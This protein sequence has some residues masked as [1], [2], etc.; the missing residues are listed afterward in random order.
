[1]E[2]F[3][4]Y[5]YPALALLV[6]LEGLG[7]PTPAVTA[8]VAASALAA[9]GQ[10]SLPA[11]VAVTL[12][13]AVLGDN[14]GYLLGRRAGRPAVLRFGRRIG[15]TEARLERAERFMATRGRNI[16]VA[17]RFVDGLRQ[18]NG[19]IAG[20]TA[21]PWRQYAPRD[22]AGGVLW[23]ALWVTIG[24]VAGNNID[25]LRRYQLWVLG[26]AAVLGLGLLVRHLVRRRRHTAG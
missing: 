2:Q 23:T 10:L 1:M 14:L 11:V 12:A 21:L 22:A 5:G 15:L 17:A 24:A 4:R 26:A 3:E 9:H 16:I 7:I 19:I 25:N 6:L 13:A 8:V 18:T 20:A